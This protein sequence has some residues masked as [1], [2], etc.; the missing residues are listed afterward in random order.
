MT[1]QPKDGGAARYLHN[2]DNFSDMCRDFAPD[3]GK[4]W[5][6]DGFSDENVVLASYGTD[7]YCGDAFVLLQK[8]GA[9]FEVHASH[10][11]WYG[12]EGQWE[13]EPTN[14]DALLVRAKDGRL[15]A[16]DYSDNVFATEIITALDA[17]ILAREATQ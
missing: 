6:P 1:E 14:L 15:G 12:L 10:C 8:D 3:Y 5:E 7:N 16:D 13:A 2:W 11:S 4:A 9:L 17:M